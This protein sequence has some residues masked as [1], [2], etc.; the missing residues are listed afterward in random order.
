MRYLKLIIFAL[1]FI[2]PFLNFLH[3]APV[4]DW[5]T[6]ALVVMGVAVAAISMLFIPLHR[7]EM[8]RVGI[9]LAIFFCSVIASGYVLHANPVSLNVLFCCL[10]VLL[11]QSC[12][13]HILLLQSRSDFIKKLSQ[14]L[15]VGGLLQVLLGTIQVFGLAPFFHG[16][17]MYDTK[18]AT[19]NIMGNIAQ[20]NLYGHYL[21]WA[22]FA[23]CYLYAVGGLR[24]AV[25]MLAQFLFA[26]LIAWSGGRLILAYAVFGLLL[27]GL[28]YWRQREN[29][30]VKR[31]FVAFMIGVLFVA[32]T[33]TFL[34]QFNYLLSLL[35]LKVE[36]QSGI[37]RFFDHGFGARRIIEW[38]KAWYIFTQHYLLGLG[39]DSYALAGNELEVHGGFPKVPESWLFA[40]CHNLF[41]QLL[42]ETG[43][44][45]TSIVLIGLVVLVRPFFR[46]EQANPEN[47]LL[48]LLFAVT[49]THSMFEYPL[50]YLPFL[51]MF[52]LILTC[53]PVSPISLKIRP[54][55]MRL[56]YL[57][58]GL[59]FGLYVVS[60]VGKFDILV[61][62]SMP[63]PDVKENQQRIQALSRMT[64]DPLW[65]DD[66]NLALARFL[67]P[68]REKAELKLK[69][70]EHLLKYRPMPF[71]LQN[72]AML[73]ALV[74][75]QQQALDQVRQ[76]IV[77]YPDMVSSLCLSLSLEQEPAYVPLRSLADRACTISEKYP[78]AENEERR[79]L[80]I[81][82]AFAAPVT[83]KPLF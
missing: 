20:R 71:I 43:V 42:A 17:V 59:L 50:W 37:D 25:L 18:N 12:F 28:W 15:F 13:W 39:W 6:N 5:W 68:S 82:N 7:L 58:C 47:L 72:S 40:H 54:A 53:S 75:K 62:Q 64:I 74:G 21:T 56:L 52:V 46:A 73:N 4:Q 38:S 10:L 49:M 14:I 69:I 33:Q 55:V 60:G 77:V 1:I 29:V 61:R 57:I 19:G 45:G 83:R 30:T 76:F 78:G 22:L 36:L 16:Y 8:P 80:A 2:A 51:S 65:Q 26:L 41:F 27:S 31:M 81:V 70:Y 48:M 35:G 63:I 3:Y 32:L 67:T 44:L 23:S 9:F 24:G 34:A 66:A 79:R 11:V